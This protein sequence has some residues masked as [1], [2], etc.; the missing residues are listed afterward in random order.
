[1][2]N[3]ASR[4]GESVRGRVSKREPDL[5]TVGYAAQLIP[6]GIALLKN[7]IVRDMLI[8]AAVKTARRGK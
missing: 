4:V 2:L 8:R 6:L 3:G 7:P 5:R 1:M